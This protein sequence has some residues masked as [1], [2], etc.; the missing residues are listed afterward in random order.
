MPTAGRA[1]V[2][3]EHISKEPAWSR[4]DAQLTGAFF[5]TLHA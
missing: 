3:T 5:I 4:A 2:M 1:L